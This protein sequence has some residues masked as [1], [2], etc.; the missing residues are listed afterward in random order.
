M[1]TRRRSWSRVAVA[2]YVMLTS[3][4]V[5]AV[6]GSQSTLLAHIEIQV[7]AG[8]LSL[9]AQDS[10][11]VDVV[12]AISERA[13]FE[14][15]LV[16]QIAGQ[17]TSSFS[18]VPVPEALERLLSGI[19]H[20]VLYARADEEGTARVVSQLW[21]LGMSGEPGDDPIGVAEGGTRA[22]VPPDTGG[23]ERSEHLL[24]LTREGATDEVL[25]TLGNALRWDRE[26]LVRTRAAMAL[27]KLGDGRAV[28][29][30][31]FALADEH[32]SVRLQAIQALS[33]IGD[34][35]ATLVLG[36]VLLHG[37]G[38]KQRI[39]AARSLWR[40]DTEVARAFL[41]EAANDPNEQV[42]R[43]ATRSPGVAR[44]SVLGPTSVAGER[45]F[46]STQ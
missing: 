33:Q 30:L 43:A 35:A 20:V 36:D 41:A 11:L 14:T 34:E 24:R 39:L 26:P 22:V 7:D 16:G 31:E 9:E 13:G 28:P 46:E 45:E 40:H 12:K 18:R 29:A 5:A 1:C 15:V 3:P 8:L 32:R 6:V 4:G 25:D 37:E 21:L 42:R 19:D 17:V 10:A 2:V 23:K 38:T 44:D 27:G